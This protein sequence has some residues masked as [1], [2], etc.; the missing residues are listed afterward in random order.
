MITEP[1]PKGR[2]WLDCANKANRSFYE[3]FQ[4]SQSQTAQ[5]LIFELGNGQWNL[6]GLRSLLED[7]LSNDTSIQN[8]EVEHRFEQI[9]QKTMLLNGCKI[10]QEGEAQRILLAIEDIS[11]RKQFELERSQ[12]LAQEQSARQ[13]AEIANR[14]KD[15][16]LSNLSHE[17]R[18]PLN[19]ILGW[20][21]LVR[22]RKLDSEAVTRAWEVVERSAKVQAQL[23][24]EQFTVN[25][26]ACD[27]FEVKFE[28]N[29]ELTQALQKAPINVLEWTFVKRL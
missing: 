27:L 13:Q 10:I 23:I 5:S 7:I 19:S 21:Q 15:E 8:V 16:L 17:L 24:E 25:V 18:N 9:G 22:T 11:D 28:S 6:P 12:L 2:G 29:A 20:A 14:A 3:T 1:S 4:V 26:E